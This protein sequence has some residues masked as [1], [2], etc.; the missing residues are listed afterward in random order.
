MAK[1]QQ[2]L[3]QMLYTGTI[4]AGL[5]AHSPKGQ[6]QAEIRNIE[7]NMPKIEKQIELA[8]NAVSPKSSEATD[9]AYTEA[10]K[11]GVQQAK[12][13]Y[14]LNPNEKN[15]SEYRSMEETLE[16][17][18]QTLKESQQKRQATLANQKEA[19]KIRQELLKGVPEVQVK[20][21]KVEV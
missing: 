15:F 21:T 13:L 6:M 18:E 20:R 10:Y 1:I 4:A 17:W 16:E 3:N 19:K 2:S 11:Q 5:Y 14:E 8:E 12:R 7:K 9:R